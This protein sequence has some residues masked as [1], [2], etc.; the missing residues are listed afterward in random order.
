MSNLHFRRKISATAESLPA[1][2]PVTV[3][4]PTGA[5]M[6]GCTVRALRELIWAG[7]IKHAKI[8]KRFVVDPAELR[9][10]MQ[11]QMVRS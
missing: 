1:V 8:G 9:E 10:F 2:H 3:T 6:L 4:L 5:A 7:K 11:R